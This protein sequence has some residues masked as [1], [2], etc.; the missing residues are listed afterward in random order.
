MAQHK[1]YHA[2]P[3]TCAMCSISYLKLTGISRGS[4]AHPFPVSWVPNLSPSQ[5]LLL[6][7]MIP[8][9]KEQHQIDYMEK[10]GT[11][12][13]SLYQEHFS[14]SFLAEMGNGRADIQFFQNFS[15]N[16][17]QYFSI[18]R[19]TKTSFNLK[20]MSVLLNIKSW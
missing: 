10:V 18:Q 8:L 16:H 17:D 19:Q 13:F 5:Q 3:E 20:K 12:N 11:E 9:E 1:N 7:N 4:L 14:S 15:Q 6:P 2:V